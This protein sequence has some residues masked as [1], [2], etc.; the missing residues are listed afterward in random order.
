[1]KIIILEDDARRVEIMRA[2]LR[3]FDTLEHCF[4]EAS[5]TMID[6]LQA[7]L[8]EAVLICLDHDLPIYRDKDGELHDF[9]TG[10]E[11]TD[12]LAHETPCCPVIIHSTNSSAAL[13]MEIVLTEAGWKAFRVIPYG[14]LEW[15]DEIWISAVRQ[16]I[17]A[18]G[19]PVTDSPRN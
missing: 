8:S 6:F 7:H 18:N 17:D 1:M 13:G 4:F 19:E 15:I 9:G 12:F 11:V 16:A 5:A 14:D 2:R 10:R 3:R